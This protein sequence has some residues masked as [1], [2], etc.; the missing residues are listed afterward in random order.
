MA[1]AL[2]AVM[3]VAVALAELETTTLAV[4]VCAAVTLA[5]VAPTST[6][7]GVMLVGVVLAGITLAGVVLVGVM[8][9]GVTLAGVVL[10]GNTVTDVALVAAVLMSASTAPSSVIFITVT[11]KVLNLG[12]KVEP[13][14]E[15][16]KLQIKGISTSCPSDLATGGFVSNGCRE[17]HATSTLWA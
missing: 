10:V 11:F 15:T 8:L 17:Q 13:L 9:A 2:G 5:G 4:I 3:P 1:V 12:F 7:V 16:C 14:T 6:L